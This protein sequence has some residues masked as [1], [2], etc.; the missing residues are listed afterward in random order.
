MSE[1]VSC[2][3]VTY[4]T[5]NEKLACLTQSEI[6]LNTCFSDSEIVIKVHAASLN[7]LDL[8]VPHLAYSFVAG[9]GAKAYGRDY[10]GVIVKKGKCVAD[11]WEIG[12]K[13][14]GSYKHFFGERGS[15]SD[16]LILD[17]VK[18]PFISHM[19]PLPKETIEKND[20]FSVQAAWPL[21]FCTAYEALTNWRQKLTPDSKILV[22]GASTSVSNTLV[23]I[24][25]NH[26]HVGTVVGVCSKNS[27]EYNKKFG[28]DYL[29]PY[30]DGSITENVGKIL[31]GDLKNEKFDL[32]FDSV[33]NSDFFPVVSKFLKPKSTNSHYVTIAGDN[34]MNYANPS[35][36][37][38]IWMFPRMVNPLRGF[39]YKLFNATLSGDSI[40]LG[41]QL[42]SEGKYKPVID[43]VYPIEDFQQA[44]DR[45]KN[46]RAKGKVL[47]K[48]CE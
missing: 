25:K 7:P 10:S 16:Y 42:L 27:I 36:L 37:Q 12:D 20:E 46:S 11:N 45:L 24:A 44:I 17:P 4:T 21:V 9:K 34:K 3:A 8:V 40:E 15:F 1:Y 30:D 13:V 6:D 18:Q 2:R 29:A 14:N 28:Y 23:Q 5:N 31:L 33:G 32:I 47:V 38:N 19:R 43:S 41:Q 26:L 48:L 22:I 39:N 35:F